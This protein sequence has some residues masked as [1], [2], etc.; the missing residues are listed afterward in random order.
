MNWHTIKINLPL[1]LL[2]IT[3]NY[4]WN[5]SNGLKLEKINDN[6]FIK[7][8]LFNG[9]KLNKLINNLNNF[10][11]FNSKTLDKKISLA[12]IHEYSEDENDFIIVPYPATSIPP[13]GIKIFIQRGRAF[14]IGSH[15]CTYYCLCA[16]KEI[17]ILSPEILNNGNILDAGTGTGILSIAIAKIGAKNITGID[18]NLE[19]IIEAEKNKKIN[20]LTDKINFLNKSVTDITDEYDIILANLYGK[21]HLEIANLLCQKT[22]QN[23]YIIISGMNILHSN[24]ILSFYHKKGLNL[25]KLYHDNEWFTAILNK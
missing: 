2:D 11:R 20:N 16:L 12:E 19:A 25:I 21:L 24:E 1:E 6:F 7:C 4:L 9:Y 13:S 15:P 18:I 3:Y 17:K 8:F 14:G 5:F 10:I 23:G 22:K